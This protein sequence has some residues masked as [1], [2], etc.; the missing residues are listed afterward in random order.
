MRP[1]ADRIEFY[2]IFR[3]RRPV[4]VRRRLVRWLMILS[5][6]RCARCCI[7]SRPANTGSRSEEG[8]QASR[9]SS[10]STIIT[11]PRRR[12]QHAEL[13]LAPNQLN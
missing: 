10:H 11:H 13:Q 7:R 2:T 3:R 8:S 6:T 1:D 12:H 5:T 4:F 9:T